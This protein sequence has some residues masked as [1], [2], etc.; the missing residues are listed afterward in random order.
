METYVGR[1]LGFFR[2]SY[3]D[4][5][6]KLLKIGNKSQFSSLRISFSAISLLRTQT[7]NGFVN[8][9]DLDLSRCNISSLET[10]VFYELIHLNV[11]NLSYNAIPSIDNSLF[12]MNRKLRIVNFKNNVLKSIGDA[13]F[14]RLDDL[15]VLFLSHNNFLIVPD[16]F[17][18]CPNLKQ[19][20][21]N[22]CHIMIIFSGAFNQIRNLTHLALECNKIEKLTTNMLENL[23]N[24][25]YLNLSDNL[26]QTMDDSCF[27][28]L[29]GLSHLYLENNCLTTAVNVF[30]F[31]YNN[32]LTELDLSQN[33]I[34]MILNGTFDTC[35]LLKVLKLM[36]LHRFESVS[37]KNLASL[38][39]FE[40][41]YKQREFNLTK[42][43]WIHFKYKHSLTI[44]KLI[45]QKLNKLTFF[46][47]SQF[48]R[49]DSLH[50][51]CIEP[52]NNINSVVSLSYI[53]PYET[54]VEKLILKKLNGFFMSDCIRG[55]NHVKYLNIQGVKNKRFSYFFYDFLFLEYLDLSFSE[56]EVITEKTFKSLVNLEHLQLGYSKLKEIGT[57]A[58]KYNFKLQILNCSNCLIDTIGLLP[59]TNLYN[60]QLLD[61]SHNC[62]KTVPENM[63]YGLNKDT[64]IIIL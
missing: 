47:C 51:E 52:N 64:C 7:F 19:L 45:F 36:V 38:T 2:E 63:F 5:L 28:N 60:L 56:I 14:S 53:F 43:F 48:K 23:T 44:L 13:A 50:I 16:D 39:H 12:F 62:L 34:F 58:F 9:I 26:I 29:M 59:F 46:N 54:P 20:Y 22:N 4:V 15:E 1:S 21:L 24:L 18:T 32:F 57:T 55:G 8:L 3:T 10:L 6:Q 25:Q 30:T 31:F 33:D 35:P 27:W 41:I 11:I 49:L 42:S 17:I 40:L 37:I 61:L